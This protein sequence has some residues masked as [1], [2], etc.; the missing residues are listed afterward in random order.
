MSPFVSGHGHSA[1][2]MSYLRAKEQQIG[3]PL[4]HLL[5]HPLAAGAAG[6]GVG[7]KRPSSVRSTLVGAGTRTGTSSSATVGG[8]ASPTG[9][10]KGVW[11]RAV[12]SPCDS[13]T[14]T[15]SRPPQMTQ[16]R[17][18]AAMQAPSPPAAVPSRCTLHRTA[19]AAGEVAAHREGSGRC[20]QP[21]LQRPAPCSCIDTPSPRVPRVSR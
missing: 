14:T 6:V 5:R 10:G 15:R 4:E 7:F 12:P 3:A 1:A 2:V 9:H 11:R 18:Q 20:L 21:S 19:V 13:N 16:L 17:V 8:T